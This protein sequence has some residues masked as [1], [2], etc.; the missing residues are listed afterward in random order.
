MARRSPAIDSRCRNGLQAQSGTIRGEGRLVMLSLV[1]VH[2][3]N[4]SLALAAERLVGGIGM[5]FIMLVS[6]TV[7]KAA[8]LGRKKPRVR[9]PGCTRG[10]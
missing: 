3:P 4:G 8:A 2:L 9:P 5:A 10:S 7:V 1:R 6:V